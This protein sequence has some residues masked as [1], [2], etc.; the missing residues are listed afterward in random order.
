M[1]RSGGKATIEG[2]ASIVLDINRVLAD[3]G[4]ATAF[5]TALDGAIQGVSYRIALRVRLDPDGGGFLWVEHGLLQHLDTRVPRSAYAIRLVGQPR[6]FGG[7]RW[8]MLCP[9]TGQRALKLYLPNGGTR[10]ASRQA[11]N[12]EYRSQRVGP[13]E[14]GDARLRRAFAALGVT[15]R[16]PPQADPRKPKWM[17]RHTYRRLLGALHEARKGQRSVVDQALGAGR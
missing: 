5:T 16:H 12:M 7:L 1:S 9:N 14:A 15:Y 13:A 3:R 17:R 10:F 6:H 2:C 11:Y 4:G 8:Y